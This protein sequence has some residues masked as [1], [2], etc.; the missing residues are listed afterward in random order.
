[1]N[2]SG[3][4]LNGV[5]NDQTRYN[6]MDIGNPSDIRNPS[7]QDNRTILQVRTD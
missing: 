1:M 3:L 4:R 6:P 5:K 7:N 2:E